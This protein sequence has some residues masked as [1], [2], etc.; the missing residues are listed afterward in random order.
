MA[1]PSSRSA[2]FT[3]TGHAHP[4]GG[5]STSEPALLLRVERRMYSLPPLTK[6]G[7]DEM[8]K[9]RL[10]MSRWTTPRL[11]RC[12]IALRDC[13]TTCGQPGREA[14]CERKRKRAGSLGAVQREREAV[15]DREEQADA[16]RHRGADSG[17]GSR[18]RV[19]PDDVERCDSVVSAY[20]AG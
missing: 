10:L 16:R 19:A 13:A 18:W 7:L 11:W 12:E 2:I 3:T 17:D 6:S 8:R 20:A 15:S 5:D 9:L 1:L 4:D 14:K